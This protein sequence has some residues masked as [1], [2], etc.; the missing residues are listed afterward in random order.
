[1]V[2]LNKIKESFC[3]IREG[4]FDAVAIVHSYE[5]DKPVGSHKTRLSA[6][7][8]PPMGLFYPTLFIPDEYPPPPRTWF[9]DYED[10]LED[11]WNVDLTRRS[12][13]SD[14]LYLGT[15]SGVS[16][17]DNYQVY[18]TRLKKD[19]LVG[20]AEAISTSILSTG[21]IDLQRKLFC[22]IQLIGGVALTD[23]LVPM[24]EDR[25]V[26]FCDAN[27]VYFGVQH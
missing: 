7:N 26:S 16:M 14:G 1:M 10:M 21:R 17:L 25:F 11:T 3:Q 5:E 27:L 6:L 2:M 4:E 24:V 8:V 12:E 13:M 23:G 19:E 15:G 20:L 22:S 18:P 9:N